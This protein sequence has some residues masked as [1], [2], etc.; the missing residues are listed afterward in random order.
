MFTNIYLSLVKGGNYMQIIDKAKFQ[1]SKGKQSLM[2]SLKPLKTLGIFILAIGLFTGGYL[3]GSRAFETGN[4]ARIKGATVYLSGTCTLVE[5]G[6]D[7]L[8]SLQNDQVQIVSVDMDKNTMT[9]IVILTREEIFCDMNK[10]SHTA[11][12]LLSQWGKVPVQPPTLTAAQVAKKQDQ[13]WKKLDKQTLV[14]SGTCRDINGKEITPNLL[15]EKIDVTSVYQPAQAIDNDDFNLTGI[16]VND[17][18]SIICNSKS[19]KYEIYDAANEKP[20]QVVEAEIDLTGKVVQIDSKCRPD[21]KYLKERPIDPKTKKPIGKVPKFYNLLNTPVQVLSYKENDKKQIIYLEGKIV[22]RNN[23]DAYGKKILCD[24]K[25]E[26]LIVKLIDS[27][28]SLINQKGE[29]IN[30]TTLPQN[31]EVVTEGEDA[32]AKKVE[33]PKEQSIQEQEK[34]GVQELLEQLDK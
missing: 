32:P 31:L 11:L 34:P 19:I 27:N 20:E 28:T 22:D 5:T 14:I 18:Q 30:P 23:P 33:A 1:L 9:G 24:S 15:R 21:P 26:A 3:L 4:A 25:E 8:P 17:K 12:P 6:Q 13:A 7:R 2:N 29:D 10:T 16:R